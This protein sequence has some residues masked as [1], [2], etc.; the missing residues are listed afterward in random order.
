MSIEPIITFKAGQCDLDESTGKVR[1]E[2]TPGYV[3]LYSDEDLLHFCWR[4]RDATLEAPELDLIMFPTDGSFVPYQNKP[5]N[6]RVFVLKFSSSSTRHLFWLQSKS[7][8]PSGNAAYFSP[9]DLKIGEVVNSLLQG[10][11]VDVQQAVSEMRTGHSNE[12]EDADMEDVEGQGGAGPGATGG[13]IREEGEGSR[14]GGAD[15]GRAT[16]SN[17]DAQSIIQN[18]LNSMPGGSGNRNQPQQKLFTTLQ[19]L[20]TPT[21]TV[22]WLSAASEG[23]VDQ[24]MQYL[25]SNLVALATEDDDASVSQSLSLAEK[26]RLV[27]RVLRSPQFSQSLASLTIAL[28]DGGLPSI[29]EA[30]NVPVQNGGYMR[31]GGVPLGGGEAV[32]AFLNGVKDVVADEGKKEDDMETD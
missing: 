32:E 8:S 5:V 28:R 23:T 16:G 19:D 15:G 24:V 17:L 29:S 21:A 30:L 14:E 20:L 18:F 6:G 12:D 27:E 11:E 25:P 2:S 4:P 3:Y 26:K 1:P 31:R 10:E 13:D 7:Q 22:S 9:R